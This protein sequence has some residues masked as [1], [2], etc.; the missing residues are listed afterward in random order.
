LDLIA[1]SLLRFKRN[2]YFQEILRQLRCGVVDFLRAP[3]LLEATVSFDRGPAIE[4]TTGRLTKPYPRR[5][6]ILM[7]H[8]CSTGNHCQVTLIHTYIG[9]K[10]SE[11]FL[12]LLVK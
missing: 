8:S 5:P 6:M 9:L 4:I 11:S 1:R 2:Y 3:E 12:D 7:D 10:W